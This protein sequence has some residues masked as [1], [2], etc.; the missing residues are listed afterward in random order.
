MAEHIGLR[1]H[2]FAHSGCK[3]T[4]VYRRNGAVGVCVEAQ[5]G[6]GGVVRRRGRYAVAVIDG[7]AEIVEVGVG[8]RALGL[9]VIVVLGFGGH[10]LQRSV[11][12]DRIGAYLDRLPGQSYRAFHVVL[13]TV[14][15][16]VNDLAEGRIAGV[17]HIMAVESYQSVIVG[18][19]HVWGHGVAGRK[20][21]HHDVARLYGVEAFQTVVF[22]LRAVKI[23]LG[24]SEP[25]G[26]GVLHQGEMHR[27]HWHARTIGHFVDPQIV[28]DE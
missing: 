26:H 13:A 11:D 10:R 24:A 7:Y 15:R 16:P 25:S 9:E 3:R 4:E 28:A 12:I 6:Q 27:S 17:Y 1:Q 23:A 2:L 8:E 18:I 14:H 20:V 21:E 5:R 19:G 22:D